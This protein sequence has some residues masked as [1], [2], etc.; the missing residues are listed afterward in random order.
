MSE[1][2]TNQIHHQ[3]FTI[4]QGTKPTF[5]E[6][7]HYHPELELHYVVKGEGVKIVGNNISGFSSGEIVFLG[8]QLPHH[9]KF[10]DT[11]EKPEVIVL[12]FL[13]DFLGRNFLELPETDMLPKL[14]ERAKNGMFI[15]G[16]TRDE[17]AGLMHK[18]IN[19]INFD[20][21]II[22]LS[23]LKILAETNVAAIVP[24][25]HS[26]C[27]SAEIKTIRWYK[28]YDYTLANYQ[29][30]IKLKDVASIGNLSVTSFCRYFK[31]VTKISY[32]DFL[33]EIRISHACRL[34]TE[35][36]LSTEILCYECGFTN[37]S[38]FYRHFKKSV[39]ITPKVYKQRCLKT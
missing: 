16:P 21:T 28:I 19:A 2:F 35:D 14:F 20:R 22:L 32:Y 36:K 23:I 26:F 5:M 24:T 11:G 15:S 25:A 3:P 10:F 18:A 29:K 33:T 37:V 30:K 4:T 13:P 6:I 12:H 8:Q 27:G 38:N 17:L 7:W 9:W 39:G 31:L 1:N 34:L